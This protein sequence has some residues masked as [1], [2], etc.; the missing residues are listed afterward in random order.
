MKKTVCIFL[1]AM[2]II[3]SLVSCG[4]QETVEMIDSTPAGSEDG[5][6]RVLVLGCDRAASLT[7]TMMVVAIDKHAERVGILQLPRDTYAEYT[8]R[9]YKKLNGA[10]N[11]LGTERLKGFLSELLDVPIDYHITL[12]ADAISKIVDAV[13]GVDVDVPQAMHYSDPE[14]DLH[15]HLEAGRTHLNGSMAEQFVRY[16]SGY[17]NADLGRLDAQKL[18]LQAF[19]KRCQSLS[20][21]ESVLVLT[22]LLTVVQTDLPIGEAVA[23][24]TTLKS[25]SVDEIPMQTLPGVALQGRSGASYYVANR[26]GAERSVREYLFAPSAR[27]DQRGVLDRSVDP[28]FHEIYAAAEERLSELAQKAQMKP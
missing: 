26:A 2:A 9:D 22:R 5:V 4:A 19:A 24:M 3:V 25:C 23:L 12:C 13:G 14:Q 6:T 28:R 15:I 8:N 18:F 11:A 10:R 27:F 21:G 16:R 7:D 20:A 17:V 1:V